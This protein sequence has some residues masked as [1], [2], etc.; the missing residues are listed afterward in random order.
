MR[1]IY[2]RTAVALLAATTLVGTPAGAQTMPTPK[3]KISASLLELAKP[4]V[5]TR[6]LAA[7]AGIS[8]P[9]QATN[10]VQVYNGYVVVQALATT[11]SAK[12][13]LINLQAKGL[14]QGT[15]YGALVSGLFPVDKLSTL[16]NVPSL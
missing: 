6:G 1:K 7:K 3:G 15:A 14:R 5:A 2:F 8:S 9:L 13:L 4:A 11:P 12:Q 16:E 10:A